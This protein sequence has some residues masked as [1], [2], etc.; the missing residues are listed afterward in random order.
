MGFVN[1]LSFVNFGLSNHHPGK[2]AFEEVL[3]PKKYDLSKI[4]G[5][6]SVKN[7]NARAK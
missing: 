3:E 6:K 4:T 2:V 1:H 7:E 5:D